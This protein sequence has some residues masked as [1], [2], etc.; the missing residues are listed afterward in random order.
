MSELLSWFPERPPSLEANE[1]VRD[2]GVIMLTEDG[3]GEEVLLLMGG[4][5]VMVGGL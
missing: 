4:M 2:D 3:G 1:E 5:E